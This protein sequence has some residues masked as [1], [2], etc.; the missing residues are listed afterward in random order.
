MTVITQL[1]LYFTTAFVRSQFA[2][3]LRR[4]VT[5]LGPVAG[6][7][8]WLQMMAP[9]H[10]QTVIDGSQQGL[11]RGELPLLLSVLKAGLTSS[12]GRGRPYSARVRGIAHAKPGVYCG[13]VSTQGSDGKYGR[14]TRFAVDT[15]ILN[16]TIA[17]VND[18]AR[19]AMILRMIDAR[20][21]R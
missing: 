5:R 20:C 18:P 21:L 1:A 10:A 13:E 15:K 11:R 4:S 14:F 8:V 6:C 3:P 16:A 2:V 17:P 19:A 12:D 7:L 9:A